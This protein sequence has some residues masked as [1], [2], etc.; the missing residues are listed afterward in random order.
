MGARAAAL[1]PVLSLYLITVCWLAPGRAEAET[2]GV[3]TSA[4]GVPLTYRAAGDGD[5]ALVFVHCWSCDGRYW[6]AQLE[7]FA[8]SHRVVA[9]DLAGHGGSGF[10]R[11]QYTV[12]AFGGDVIAVIEKLNLNRV[13]L[14]GHSIGGPIAVEA[15]SQSPS[16]IVGLIAVDSFETG[17]EWPKPEEL[18]KLMTSFEENFRDQ[19]VGIVRSMFKPS[20]DPALVTWISHDMASAPPEVALSAWRHAVLW[21]HHHRTERT[22]SLTVPLWN[23]NAVSQAK[24]PA[25]G[26]I[27][28]IPDVGHFLPQVRP[29][30]FNQALERIL[31]ELS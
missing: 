3:A 22:A 11:E 16:R 9:L 29:N 14:I 27:I 24:A 7:H 17:T 6:D 12:S 15:A 2:L 18:P 20:A 31:A 30:E 1:L 13:V 26:N 28:T 19:T 21:E 23:I 5:T 10:A 25:K 8:R 4:D